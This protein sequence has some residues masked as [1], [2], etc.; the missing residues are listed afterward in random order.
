MCVALSNESRTADFLY[1]G[2]NRDQYSMPGS[3][4]PMFDDPAIPDLSV[5]QNASSYLIECR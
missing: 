4:S 2:P 1:G 5:N 3:R